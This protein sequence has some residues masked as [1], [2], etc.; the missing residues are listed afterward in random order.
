MK[1]SIIY[2]S[3][4]GNTKKVAATI[5]DAFSNQKHNVKLIALKSASHEDIVSSDLFGIGCPCFSSQ[6]P[7]PSKK[8]IN[9]LPFLSQKKAFVF[10]TSGAAPGRVLYDLSYL[11]RKRGA[12]IIGGFLSRGTLYHPA[13]CLLGR[14]PNRP[15]DEDLSRAKRFANA[16]NRH[17][18][19][20]KS[21]L[22]SESHHTTLKRKN[23]FYDLVA[24]ICRDSFLRFALPKPKHNIQKCN[25]CGLCAKECPMDNI[26]L[27]PFPVV[28]TE[29]I[30]CYRC[31]AVCP[32]KAFNANWW[33]GN[34]AIQ[35]FYNTVFERWF[36]D[37]E[38]GEPIY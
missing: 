23:G 19:N 28:S 13:P 34:I 7:T 4:T 29:C 15:N 35:F 26:T 38:P 31:L 5:A 33:Q 21:G 27:N 32:Q 1:I 8:F 14:I 18:L 12:I 37:L 30:R 6:A 36:G 22:I 24:L 9:G 20:N 16:I 3:Q 2:F 25:K 10:A 17:I 11:I